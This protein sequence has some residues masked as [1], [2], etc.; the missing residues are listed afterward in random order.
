MTPNIQHVP[1]QSEQLTFDFVDDRPIAPVP[2]SQAYQDM[3]KQSFDDWLAHLTYSDS[4]ALS[5]EQIELTKLTVQEARR[6]WVKLAGWIEKDQRAYYEQDMPISSDAAYD[7]RMRCLQ[8]L[9]ATFSVLS[10]PQSPTQRVGGKAVS[11]FSSVRHPSAMMSLDDVFS[12]EELRDWYD[13]ILRDLQW[14]SNKPLPM[15]CEVKIDGL[16]LNLIYRNGKLVQALSRGDGV[17]GEDISANVQT[18]TAIPQQ[19]NTTSNVNIPELV[20]IRGEVFM[21]WEN[22]YKLNETQENEGK[23]A[24]ANPRN[25]AAGSLRQKD[26]HVTAMRGLSFFAHGLG[27]IAWS[28]ENQPAHRDETLNQSDAYRYYQAW[29]VPVS[30]YTRTVNSF[31]EIES[32]I[33]YYGEHR[34]DILHALDGIVVK[35]NDRALQNKLGSTSR[36]PRWAIAYK[37]PPEEVNTILQDIVVQVGRTGRVTPVAVLK[38]VTVAGSTISRTT[39]HNA[40]EVEHKG[41]LIGDTVIVRKAGDVIPE[42]VGPV[43]SQRKGNEANLRHFIMPTVCPSCGARLAPTKEGDKDIRCPNVTSCPAQLTERIIHL[44]SRQAFDIENLGEAAAL[45]LTNPENSRPQTSEVYCPD[46]NKVV[47][48]RGESKPA[49]VEYQQLSLPQRQHPVLTS[50]ADLFTLN[51]QVLKDVKVWKEIPLVEVWQEEDRDHVLHKRSRKIGGSGLWKQVPAFWTL[52]TEAKVRKVADTDEEYDP[53]YPDYCVPQDAHVVDYVTRGKS[54]HIYRVP[55]YIRPSQTTRSML[56]EIEEKTKNAPLWRILVALSIRRLG[57]PTARLIATAFPS[58]DDIANASLESLQEIDGVGPEIAQAVFNWFQVAQQPNTW[59]GGI[60]SAWRNAGVVGK[61]ESVRLQRT[62]E[63]KSIV[64]TG[65]LENFSR[66]S[67]K[68]AIMQR[69]GKAASSVSMKTYCVIVGAHPGSKASKAQELNVPILNE[70]AFGI[71]LETGN[72]QEAQDSM[73]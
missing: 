5:L 25:A 57:P 6:L 54:E 4:D 62:L 39:L 10:T 59:Q 26:P 3:S 46:I 24:F 20:E 36:A 8:A 17:V 44:A 12:L 14:D 29:G 21:P 71:L 64:V 15:T 72:L 23:P 55:Q 52:P 43:I 38:P 33:S 31:Y 61:V 7:A 63:G 1:Q 16:A 47:I 45:A 51:A 66:D 56:A 32:M 67:A 18:I 13:S 35:V 42:L 53:Q 48:Q 65:T 73:Q 34:A 19:L 28:F 68:E 22:F 69:G 40:Y 11:D 41:V 70:R 49:H 58:L 60:L 37:Y 9:E 2:E 27:T 50:E 30:P